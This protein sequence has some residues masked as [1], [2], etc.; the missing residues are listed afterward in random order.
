MTKVDYVAFSGGADSTAM[1]IYLHEQSQDFELVFADTGAEL[2]ET[3][4]M[5]T[6]VAK[7]LG[8]KL[9]VVSNG[10]FYQHLANYGFMLPSPAMRYCTRLLK[11]VPQDAYF[12][13]APV[14]VG[15]RADEAHRMEGK[16][17]V[18]R[19]LVDAGFD[20][21][22]VHD[23]C[24]RYDLLNPVYK[25]RSNVSCLCC[26]FQKV[27]DWHGLLK[28]HPELYA[29]A[30]QWEAQ[31]IAWHEANPC[32]NMTYTWNKS[33]TLTQLRT[34]DERQCALWPD[35]EEEPCAICAA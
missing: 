8:K 31:S 35:P 11:Q 3:Y 16:P 24:R 34:A 1:A 2:P 15:I 18:V 12:K 13:G 6:R 29:L 17:G 4:W 25:W 23:L 21:R 32:A 5:V 19:P 30:E 33:F 20:K 27:S 28:H 26:F 14:A 10:T 7:T 22:T 9:T